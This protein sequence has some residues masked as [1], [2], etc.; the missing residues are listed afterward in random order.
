[1]PNPDVQWQGVSGRTYT[2]KS[3]EFNTTWFALPGN[4][5]FARESFRGS[6]VWYAIYIGETSDFSRRFVNHHAQQC[7]DRGGATHIHARVNQ[8]GLQSRLDEEADL[9]KRWKPT[10]NQQ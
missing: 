3:F 9:R 2:Y 10:C 8:D 5:I 1:M 7:I 6:N 4:Y